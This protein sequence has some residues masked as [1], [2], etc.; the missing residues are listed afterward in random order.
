M[1]ISKVFIL[2]A[3]I[4]ATLAAEQNDSCSPNQNTL[5]DSVDDYPVRIPSQVLKQL[6][7]ISDNSKGLFK[8]W[9]YA[10]K[11]TKDELLKE[12]VRVTYVC[13]CT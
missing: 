12:K 3:L 7:K 4:C 1:F 9:Q 6:T 5:S 10:S 11:L 8:V 13:I 2:C